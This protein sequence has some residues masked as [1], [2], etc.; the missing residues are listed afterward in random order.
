MNQEHEYTL[1][2]G[3]NRS[4]VGQYIALLSATTSAVI[5]FLLLTVV[6]FAKRLGIPA[7]VPP[8]VL[9][10]LGAGSVFAVLYWIFNRYAWRWAP[11]GPLLKI[12]NLSGDW[13]CDGRTINPNGT[14]R[15]K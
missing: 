3:V 13:E 11:L 2:G 10:L 1:L 5:V 8:S 15:R 7:N 12:A 14:A 9:S 4:K 6:D